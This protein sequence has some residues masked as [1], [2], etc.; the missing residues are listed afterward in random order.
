MSGP[1][2]VSVYLLRY[3][4]RME[5]QL[6]GQQVAEPTQERAPITKTPEEHRAELLERFGIK[7]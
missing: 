3:L 6:D 1:Q 4:D 2:H 7:R 5:R